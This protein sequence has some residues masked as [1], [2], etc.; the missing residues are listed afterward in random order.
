MSDPKD[1]LIDDAAQACWHIRHLLDTYKSLC[2]GN[3]SCG[4]CKSR[5]IAN[6]MFERLEGVLK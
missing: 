1:M 3:C 5:K 6:D 2:K 4:I